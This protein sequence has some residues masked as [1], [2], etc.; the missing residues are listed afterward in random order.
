MRNQ[1][2][3]HLFVLVF[4]DDILIAS[5]CEG[6]I[7][8]F[9]NELRKEF[10]LKD[11]G[12]VKYFLGIDIQRNDSGIM[13][14][15]EGYVKDILERFNLSYCNPCKTPT[16]LSN[17]S[18]GEIKDNGTNEKWPYR[19]LIGCLQYLCLATR[20][21]I[22]NTVV[23][24]A[25]F[26]TSPNQSHWNAAKRVLRY[27][28]GTANYGLKYSKTGKSVQGYCDADWGSCPIDRKSYSGYAFI[29]GGASISWSSRKQRTVATS[30]CEAEFVS[31]AE[32]VKEGIYLQSLLTEMNLPGYAKIS[33]NTDS[34][35]AIFLAQD[36]VFHGRSK[37][38]DI[39]YHFIRGV[40]KEN[41]SIV[42]GHVPTESML[43]DVLTKPLPSIKHN[44]CIDGL[45]LKSYV[46]S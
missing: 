46:L 22:T 6:R 19:E 45:G 28:K 8:R 35:S 24:L 17:S 15:Q 12:K 11:Y 13:L 21:D 23:K 2:S 36:P 16:E 27:L 18:P 26:V 40:L 3:V 34:R 1:D 10:E 37:H 29:L 9:K 42:L 33:L 5:E 39:K 41:K 30:S 14:S 44:K 32:A 20:P 38:I 43:A 7:T 31:L 25:Q 4:V